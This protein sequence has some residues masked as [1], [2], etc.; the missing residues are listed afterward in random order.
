MKHYL[1]FII[2]L[3]FATSLNAQEKVPAITIKYD[4]IVEFNSMG[5]GTS[6]DSFLK[7]FIVRFNKRYSTLINAYRIE[8]CGRE[9]E[10]NILFSLSSLVPGNRKKFITGLKVQVAAENKKTRLG[11]GKGNIDILFDIL[12]RDVKKCRGSL[13]KWHYQ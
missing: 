2:S 3:L 6:S 11:T 5:T 4:A 8:G 10:F 7:E 12:A 13:S 1:T 9:G